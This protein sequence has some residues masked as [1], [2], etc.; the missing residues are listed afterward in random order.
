MD[1]WEHLG[2][3]RMLIVFEPDLNY[4]K[5]FQAHLLSLAERDWLVIV[6]LSPGS[7]LRLEGALRERVC[8]LVDHDGTLRL[9]YQAAPGTS[10]AVEKNGRVKQ[11]WSSPPTPADILECS[12]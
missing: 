10:Y 5:R 6:V 1:L 9:R 4:L 8:V 12:A 11:I 3:K 7:P 2:F